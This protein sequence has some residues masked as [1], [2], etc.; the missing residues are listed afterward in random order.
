MRTNPHILEINIRTWLNHLRG[1]YGAEISLVSIPEHE[2]L[3]F[4]RL[5]FDAVWL[6]GVWTP[7]PAAREIAR[8][9]EPI[10]ENIRKISPDFKVEDV[11][12]SPY[13]VYDYRLN[14]ALGKPDELSLLH[15]KLNGMGLKLILDFVSNHLARDHAFLSE[16]PE[17]FIRGTD[18]DAAH[19]PGFFFKGPDGKTWF[20]HGRDPNFAPWTDT[21]QLNYFSDRA[22]AHMLRTLLEVAQ[23]CD[24]VRCDMAMLTLNDIHRETW[25]WLL[26]RQGFTEKGE[27]WQEAI[28]RVREEHPLFTFLAE[29]YW[30]L[31]WHIQQLG[32]NYTYDKVLYD[33]LRG[34]N[35]QDVKG[36]LYAESLYQK[37]S[38]RFIDNH[39]EEAALV[40]FGRE[41]SVAAAIVM[42]TLRGMR[43]FNHGQ[44]LGSSKRAPVQ[45]LRG[46]YQ[47]DP[48]IRLRYERLLDVA[49]DSAFHG[50]EWSLV[51]LG[52]AAK[53]DSSFREI[54][55]WS[56]TQMRTIKYVLVN[57]S[58]G[59]ARARLPVKPGPRGAEYTFYD[60]ISDRFFTRPVDE[61]RNQGLYI[62]L[63]PYGAH[64]L[65]LEF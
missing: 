10:L 33:R 53:D 58:G 57:Y 14:P 42:S 9:H 52:P 1:K 13:A 26:N 5:G 6:M 56:W 31:E 7:S 29:V 3:A 63:P 37:R 39:D 11:D 48:E 2:W 44:I 54:L 65:D 32:F 15:G 19:N 30:G 64:L 50:G 24:G 16:C 12:A 40:A 45:Y 35:A 23:V 18:D 34:T 61:V 43:L 41:K 17:C 46:D 25:G 28:S 59:Y 47:G 62:E 49:D 55:S 4:K 60:E 36:H 20:A 21:V 8:Q 27:F 51:E 22:R 38:L